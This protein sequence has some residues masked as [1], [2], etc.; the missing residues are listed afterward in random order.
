M[1]LAFSMSVVVGA[2]AGLVDLRHQENNCSIPFPSATTLAV[3]DTID[4]NPTAIPPIGSL[5]ARNRRTA[6]RASNKR[7]TTT[8][9]L[10]LGLCCQCRAAIK[11]LWG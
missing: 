5:G 1:S 7:P 3:A 6:A 2:D 4:T 11:P 8:E 10:A 9:A